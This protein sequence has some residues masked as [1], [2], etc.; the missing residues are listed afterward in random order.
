[1]LLISTPG[2][3]LKFPSVNE[4]EP[5]THKSHNKEKKKNKKKKNKKRTITINYS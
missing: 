5:T 1:M 2:I 3:T 4:H